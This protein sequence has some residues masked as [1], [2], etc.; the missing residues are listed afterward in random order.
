MAE[1]IEPT[2]MIGKR[3]GKIEVVAFAGT[4]FLP[5]GKHEGSGRKQG[6]LI[7]QLISSGKRC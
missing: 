3:Y 4:H 6:V 7:W 2:D 1:Y 5:L